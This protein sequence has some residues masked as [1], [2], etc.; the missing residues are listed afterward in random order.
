MDG[1]SKLNSKHPNDANNKLQEIIGL[2][3]DRETF[4]TDGENRTHQRTAMLT[5]RKDVSS[6]QL[7]GWQGTDWKDHRNDRWNR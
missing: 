3:D 4:R 6:L 5:G 7:F 2:R 1:T